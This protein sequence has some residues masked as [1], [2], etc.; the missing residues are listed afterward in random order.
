MNNKK[1]LSQAMSV[2]G[3]RSAEKL[4]KEQRRL[5]AKK[6]VRARWKKRTDEI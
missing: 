6:A 5:R 2:L 4:T 3:K 1:L